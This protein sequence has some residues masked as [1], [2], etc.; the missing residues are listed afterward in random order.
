MDVSSLLSRVKS[1]NVESFEKFLSRKVLGRDASEIIVYLAILVYTAVF[2]YF[3]ILKYD[4]FRA[5]AWDL[6]IFNQALWTTVRDGKLFYQTVELFIN[7]SGNFFGSHFSPILFLVLPVYAVFPAPQ[8]LLAFQSLILALGA[9]PLYFFTRDSL[10]HRTAGVAFSIAYLMYPPLHGV[11]WFDFHVQAFLPLLFFC[12]M[13]FL[14]KEKWLPFFASIALSLWV[15]ENVPIVVVFIG[16]YCFWLYRKEVVNSVKHRSLNDKRVVVPFLVVG[17]ALAWM[18]FALWVQNTY[19][20]INPAYTSFY[21]AVDNYS[22]LGLKGDPLT[23]PIYA[24]LN[25]GRT[26]GALVYDAYLKLLYIILLFGPLYFLSFRSNITAI[27][28]AWL[29]PV[30]LSN[31]APYYLIGAHFP[32]YVISFIFLGAILAVKGKMKDPHFPGVNSVVKNLLVLALLSSIF[33]SPL[34]PLLT[35]ISTTPPYFSDYYPPSVTTHEVLLQQIVKLVPDNASV[36]T[37]NNIF[38]HFSN[39]VNAYVYPVPLVLERAPPYQMN[40]Y[41]SYIVANSKYVLVDAKTD[42]QTAS[43]IIGR[44]GNTSGDFGLLTQADAIYLYM[45]GYHGPFTHFQ[46]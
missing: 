21:K 3:T 32:A 30:F 43:L 11:N 17:T 33:I 24:I 2:S 39:R 45:R 22:V 4:S 5:Y 9:F 40:Q 8:T 23:L 14:Q 10:H 13:Y 7:P 20:P 28:L 26:L 29:V 16:L 12:A 19:F 27:T 36:L 1:V 34:S 44:I 6:G 15:A 35:T 41:L 37:Q 46:P 38:P 18:A 31:Y 42:P 25:P